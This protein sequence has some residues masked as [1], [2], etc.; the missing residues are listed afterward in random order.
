VRQRIRVVVQGRSLRRRATLAHGLWVAAEVTV[1]L[2]VVVLLLVV[3]QLWWTNR[4]ARQGA[5]HKVQAMEREWGAPAAELPG[6]VESEPVPGPAAGGNEAGVSRDRPAVQNSAPRWDQTY[7]I[8]RIPRLGVVAPV[9]QGIGKRGVL[10]KGYVGHYPGTA[11]PGEAGNFAVAGHRN[12]HG[13]PFRHINRLRGGDEVRVETREGV[14]LYVIDASLAQ[15]SSR[16]TGV[17][18]RVPRSLVKPSAGYREP[19]YYLTLTTCTPEFSSKYRL[20]V[21]GKLRSMR[22]R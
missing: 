15:T 7:A 14:Y 13:E 12:T 6:P 9:A 5:E 8:L 18:A 11:Q 17:I 16:D 1:T 22:P 3:H 20:V 10:D 19:G 21:W 4:Q 2:G